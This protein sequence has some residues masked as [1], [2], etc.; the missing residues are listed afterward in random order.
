MWNRKKPFLFHAILES[1]ADGVIAISCNGDIVSFNQEFVEM[2]QVPD[3]ITLS[4]NHNQWLAFTG[5]NL[6]TQK[7]SRRVR[8]S[9]ANRFRGYD[10][11]DLKD[12]R[13]FERYSSL[14]GLVNKSSAGV[15][16]SEHHQT[17]LI[18]E[19][20]RQAKLNFALG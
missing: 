1:T 6:K 18:E 8:N 3:S 16:L 17:K 20:L 19:A 13:V 7:L 14:S 9:T 5:T 2:W 15:E 10:T 4:R 11:L 12:G